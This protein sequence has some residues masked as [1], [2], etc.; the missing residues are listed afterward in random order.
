M[1]DVSD[2]EPLNEVTCPACGTLNAVGGM[3][4]PFELQEVLGHGGMG[5][6]Y[7]ARDV[8]LDRPV[9]LKLLHRAESEDPGQIEKLAAEASITASI[10][11]P[12]VV[13]VYTTGEDRGRFY[14]AMELVDKGTLDSL[15][16]LQERVAEAQALDIGI[17]I[18]QG[19]RAALQHGLIHRDI[20]PGNILFSDA[21]TAKIVDFGLAMFA[22]DAASARGEIWG[23]PYYVAPEKLD[24]K[25]EDFRSDM[26][27]LG[28]TLFHA[29]AGRPPFE[30]ENASL[31]ALKHLKSQAVSLQAFAPWVA[32]S[33]SF[34]INRTLSRDPDQRY[35]SYDE[36]IQHLQY[37]RHELEQ[38][39][40]LP[41]EQSRRVVVESAEGQRAMSWLV[42]GVL[43]VIF[44]GG[45]GYLAVRFL[46][47]RPAPA[48][49]VGAAHGTKHDAAYESARQLLLGGDARGA[50][51]AFGKLGGARLKRP[52][53]DWVN[54]HEGLAQWRDG[55]F[56][57]GQTVLRQ[58]ETRG[59]D[60]SDPAARKIID[61]LVDTAATAAG[62]QPAPMTLAARVDTR[63]HEALALLLFGLQNW[64]LDRFPEAEF[65]LKKF[66]GAQTLDA[67]WVAPYKALA[68]DY[69]SDLRHFHDAST[70]VKM[71]TSPDLK[72]NAATVL[73]DAK[74]SL[75]AGGPLRAR[76]E[77]MKRG[78]GPIPATGAPPP[79]PKAPA[80]KPVP[81]PVPKP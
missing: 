34:V 73:E 46:G 1:L 57:E 25:P 32:S 15:I 72:R 21:H 63:S 64:H 58:I 65:F 8:S 75:K 56:A 6:V 22:A 61:F 40:R 42:L 20:K 45:G 49:L 33:T 30:A 55:S 31:V 13:R 70:A 26:Y 18:A 23:T 67:E 80:T 7:K 76:L 29:I 5:V 36:L 17:Q 48:S 37:A 60:S 3:I 24:Q 43:A 28:A 71:A 9:A 52:M 68:T 54:L 81:K 38:K 41:A 12:N 50:A 59:R 10:N 14:I 4:G 2:E 53:L 74:K 51:A 77:A 39:A 69:L 19:L 44:L 66:D 35:Q 27:S 62:R 11:H 78:L 47:G 16:T 79:P